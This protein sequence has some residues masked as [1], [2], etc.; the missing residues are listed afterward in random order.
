MK[1]SRGLIKP[2]S[3]KVRPDLVGTGSSSMLTVLSPHQQALHQQQV[4]G[5]GQS[6]KDLSFLK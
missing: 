6:T 1:G 5:V 3:T 4:S 2:K